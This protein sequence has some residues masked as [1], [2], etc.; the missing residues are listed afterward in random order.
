LERFEGTHWEKLGGKNLVAVDVSGKEENLV[1]LD[2]EGKIS[3]YDLMGTVTMDKSYA[4]CADVSCG[5]KN[6]NETV[7]LAK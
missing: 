2:K 1:V 3:I 7:V 4:G 5:L 6:G